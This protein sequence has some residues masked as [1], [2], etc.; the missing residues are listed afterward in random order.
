LT[1][2]SPRQQTTGEA[3]MRTYT[4]RNTVHLPWRPKAEREIIHAAIHDIKVT[5]DS[6]AAALLA[7]IAT[8]TPAER[9]RAGS[10]SILSS[11]LPGDGQ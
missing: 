9:Q 5:A 11:T 4:I 3:A 7:A 6:G 8:M 10:L 1:P 2:V